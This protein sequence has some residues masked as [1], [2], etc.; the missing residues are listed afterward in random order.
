MTQVPSADPIAALIGALDGMLARVALSGDRAL[1]RQ[2]VGADA[3]H[4]LTGI[5]G[6]ARAV[7]VGAQVEGRLA[8]LGRRHPGAVTL[9]LGEGG[10]T[11]GMMML[12]WPS[13]GIVTLLDL[14]LLPGSRRQGRG[15]KALSALCGV[16]DQAGRTLR[17]DLFYDNPARR[18]L[19]RAGFILV[20]DDATDIVLERRPAGFA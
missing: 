10:R 12:D 13:S 15:G 2:I 3:A 14:T 18:L 6:S 9:L 8:A 4:M 5:P 20:G 16:A 7:L 11:I 1:L 19:A 17:A